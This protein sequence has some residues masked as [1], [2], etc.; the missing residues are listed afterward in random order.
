LATAA[1]RAFE[2]ILNRLQSQILLFTLAMAILIM[3][4]GIMRLDNSIIASL[5]SF[6]WLG[7]ILWLLGERKKPSGNGA[8]KE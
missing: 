3:I 2:L 4:A 8:T 7:G 1:W 5:V 6:A